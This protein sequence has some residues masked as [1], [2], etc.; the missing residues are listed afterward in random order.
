M[1][2]I[3]GRPVYAAT[4]LVGFLWCQHLTQLGRA[5]LAGLA[6]KPERDD[7]ELELIRKRGF[8]HEKR[9]IR[10]LE[11]AGRRVTEILPD[12]SETDHVARLR[13]SVDATWDAMRRGDDVIYQA[14]FFDGTWRGHADFLKRVEA[15]SALGDWCYEV[16]DTKLVI[17]RTHPDSSGSRLCSRSLRRSLCAAPASRSGLR[18]SPARDAA[19]F[20]Q[21]RPGAQRARA[22]F[23]GR[24]GPR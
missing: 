6:T 23:V 11:A 1:Q 21:A 16:A 20:T 18:A 4:D 15:P 8:A 14:A 22:R 10:E 17:H 7:P 13:Q 9:Y 24:A 2:L 19:L 3:D 12:S 5:T